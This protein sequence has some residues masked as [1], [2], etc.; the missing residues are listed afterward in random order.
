[1]FVLAL[2]RASGAVE[3]LDRVGQ[4]ASCPPPVKETRD[5]TRAPVAVY[6]PR[7]EKSSRGLALHDHLVGSPSNLTHLFALSPPI[8][9]SAIDSASFRLGHAVSV[10]TLAREHALMISMRRTDNCFPTPSTT[11]TRAS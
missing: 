10:P 1:M 5:T 2:A 8:V 6:R 9:A 11:S 4:T 7:S 3:S